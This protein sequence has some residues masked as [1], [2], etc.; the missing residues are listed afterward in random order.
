MSAFISYETR[1]SVER[2]LPLVCNIM[3][4][5]TWL[6][7]ALLI[8]VLY[9]STSHDSLHDGGRQIVDQLFV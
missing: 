9:Q 5:T 2:D 8:F 7:R 6:P 1:S 3:I 4:L